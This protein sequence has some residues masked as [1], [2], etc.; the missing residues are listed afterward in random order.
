MSTVLVAI[1]GNVGDVAKTLKS[2][3]EAIDRLGG[4]R[5]LAASPLYRTAPV[6]GPAGQPAFLNGAISLE[7]SLAP[8]ELMAALLEIE[9][10]H[11]RVR[12]VQDG[13]RTV[14]LDML[15]W[16][17]LTLDDEMVLLPHPRL[18]QRAFVLKP[19]AD[20]APTA[21]HPAFKKTVAELLADLGAPE[22]IELSGEPFTPSIGRGE[23]A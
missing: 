6:G 7:T 5:V 19:L 14:D 9:K 21:L 10:R 22:G 15:L 13:P 3:V 20:I 11:G 17:N 4:V 18:H 8:R 16:D 23:P 1:G 2:A 12:E